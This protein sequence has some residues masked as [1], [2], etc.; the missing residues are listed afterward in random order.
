ME[1]ERIKR[2]KRNSVTK[3]IGREIERDRDR[4][5]EAEGQR[6]TDRERVS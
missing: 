3:E 2:K 5:T 4:E 1:V 6:E